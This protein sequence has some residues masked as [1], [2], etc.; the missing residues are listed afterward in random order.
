MAVAVAIVVV[1]QARGAS[2]RAGEAAVVAI[3]VVVQARGALLGEGLAVAG[4]AP[5]ELPDRPRAPAGPL[6][7]EEGGPSPV[8]EVL[9]R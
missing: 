3:A 2:L 9:L 5:R 4:K 8:R 7:R 1:L 6:L